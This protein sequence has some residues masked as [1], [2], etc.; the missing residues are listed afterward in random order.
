MDRSAMGALGLMNARTFEEFMTAAPIFDSAAETINFATVDGH[1]GFLVSGKVPKRKS[2][3]SSAFIRDGTNKDEDWTELVPEE[4][5]PRSIDP[6]EGFIVSCNNRIAPRTIKG[7]IGTTGPVTARAVRAN[8]ILKEKIKNG[9]LMDEHDMMKMQTDTVDVFARDLL[10]LM[11][12]LIAKYDKKIN[13]SKIPHNKRDIEQF[14]NILRSWDYDNK[15]NSKG[16]LLYNVWVM[17][18]KKTL[19]NVQFPDLF[20]RKMILN[21]YH[22]VHFLGRMIKSWNDGKRLNS[23]YCKNERNSGHKELSCIYNLFEAL[24][25]AHNHI[26]STLGTSQVLLLM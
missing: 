26:V 9:E 21:M 14:I 15:A 16:A 23:K 4:E 1:I 20:R 18:L 7:M 10:P 11:I 3:V 13:L 19:L 8:E 17:E 24:I 12:K 25:N 2:I 6:S 22:T 5:M